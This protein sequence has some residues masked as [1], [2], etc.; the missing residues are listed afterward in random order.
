MSDTS[1][2]ILI[3]ESKR[4][5]SFPSRPVP[6]EK[7]LTE[8]GRPRT[9]GVAELERV[10]TYRPPL[11]K[12]GERIEVPRWYFDAI[13]GIKVL[14]SV[15]NRRTDG[16]AVGVTRAERHAAREAELEAAAAKAVAAA[17]S[18][19]RAE[20]EVAAKAVAA[21]EQA[22]AREAE[23]AKSAAQRVA[24]LERE[25]AKLKAAK[26]DDKPKDDKPKG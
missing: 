20:R 14:K 9:V 25:L 23:A 24:E 18:S 11:L 1:P 12:V 5:W 16:I 8:R 15:W 22:A 26:A 21:A 10:E 19:A 2:I 3:N 4:A 6:G 17:E 13:K 7:R